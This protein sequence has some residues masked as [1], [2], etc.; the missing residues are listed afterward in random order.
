M[1]T[2][3]THIARILQLRDIQREERSA[4][5]E[6]T[7][8]A[9]RVTPET[10]SALAPVE[11]SHSV[12]HDRTPRVSSIRTKAEHY[13]GLPRLGHTHDSQKSKGERVHTRPHKPR[14]ESTTLLVQMRVHHKEF[15][16]R[17]SGDRVARINNERSKVQNCER[18]TRTNSGN[19]V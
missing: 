6:E 17:P 10:A 15:Q 13:K 4:S 5:P 9:S 11:D 3:E 16:L 14:N 18:P 1:L 2:R 12:S 8:D 7:V 19:R